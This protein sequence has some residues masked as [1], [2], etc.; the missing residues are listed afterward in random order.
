M[1][2]SILVSLIL[3]ASLISIVNA[4]ITITRQDFPGIGYLVVSAIDEVTVVDPGQSGMGQVWDFSNLVP[5]SYDSTYWTSPVGAP[6]YQDYPEASIATNH[7][8]GTFPNG[9]YNFNYRRLTDQGYADVGDE[10]LI[11]LFGDFYIAIH[12]SITPIVDNMTFPFNY[13]DAGDQ[14]I[15]MAWITAIRQAGVTTD[16]SKTVSHM[17]VNYLADASGTMILPDGSFPV[18]RVK[19]DVSTVDTGYVWTDGAWVYD[20][21]TTSTWTQFK[22]FANDFGEVGSYMSGS[23]RGTNGFTFFKSE[24]LV[25]LNEHLK[26]AEFSIYPNPTSSSIRIISKETFERVDIQ[27]NTGRTVMHS[28]KQ[29]SLDVSG[30]APGLYFIRIFYG[31]SMGSGKFYKL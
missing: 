7:N 25:G 20:S 18:L 17:S 8:P 3:F 1:K 12:I 19:M 26:Q 16:S 6:L 21:D 27:D 28:D 14:A 30:L 23:K 22:W 13:G 11:N 5:T 31:N 9:G 4:Q 10:T 15:V 24:T 2:R 29:A